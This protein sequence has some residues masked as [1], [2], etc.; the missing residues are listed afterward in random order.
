M[1]SV[2]LNG[3]NT[4]GENIADNGGAKEAYY[5]YNKWVERNGPEG[6][7]P[8]LKYNQ[9]QLFWI[10]FGQSRCTVAREGY[11]KNQ[12]LTGV[13]SLNEFRIN[14]VLN[15]MPE[16]AYDFNCPV[17]TNMNPVDKCEVW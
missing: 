8:G 11:L 17:G 6:T 15:N 10:S 1:I 13:H 7:L 5:A 4:Q 16:F 14:G 3:I 12:I 2:Q 9:N